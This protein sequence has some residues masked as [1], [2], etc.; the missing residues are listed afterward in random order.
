MRYAKM[1]NGAPEYFAARML[2]H[3]GRV[4]VNP[5]GAVL[6]E[7]GYLPVCTCEPPNTKEGEIAAPRWQRREDGIYQEWEIFRVRMPE[8]RG[9]EG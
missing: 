8:S 2:L 1:K 6:R 7:A 5:D 4:Y 9:E 3:A